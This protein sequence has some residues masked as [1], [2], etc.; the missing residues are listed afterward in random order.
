MPKRSLLL[1]AAVLLIAAC[2]NPPI[3][4]AENVPITVPETVTLADVQRAIVLAGAQRGWHMT[5]V[6]PGELVATHT[7]S[8]HTATIAIT[9]DTHAYSIRYASTVALQDRGTGT[10]H[11]TYNRWI[12]FLESDINQQLA[13]LAV[14][15]APPT[16][17]PAPPPDAGSGGADGGDAAAVPAPAAPPPA[18]PPA[19][20]PPV[21]PT[22]LAI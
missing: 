3:H 13:T 2:Q 8:G 5:P 16:S 9:F 1:V 11:P 15:P 19:D 10:I 12:Q 22:R 6:A 21:E 18:A 20:M 7:R 17:D 14:V 4:N